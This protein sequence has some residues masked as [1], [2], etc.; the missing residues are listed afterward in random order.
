MRKRGEKEK[1]LGDLAGLS[2]CLRVAASPRRR[3][4]PPASADEVD[5]L[6]AVAFGQAGER[7]IS[8]AND[9]AVSLKGQAFGCER[10]LPDKAV[11]RCARLDFAC[12]SVDFDAQG[13]A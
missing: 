9:F 1:L 13:F 2:F 5:N 6:Y 3:I 8:A 11:E 12:F 4:A 7:P 10:E